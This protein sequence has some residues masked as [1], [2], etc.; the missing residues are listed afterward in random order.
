MS[1]KKTPKLYENAKNISRFKCLNFNFVKRLFF[2]ELCKS[3]K[4]EET[5]ALFSYLKFLLSAPSPSVNTER[6]KDG[7]VE[8][9]R[10]LIV[11]YAFLC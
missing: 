3:Y 9:C 11:I 7:Q 10:L 4:I 8:L 5:L 1:L 2:L 6:L